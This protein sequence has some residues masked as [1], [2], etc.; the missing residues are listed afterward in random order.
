[1]VEVVAP[2][3]S[4]DAREGFLKLIKLSGECL[5]CVAVVAEGEGFA[6]SM[7]RTVVA[8]M[9]IL[10]RPAV[11]MKVFSTVSDAATWIASQRKSTD[12]V[13][14]SADEITAAAERVR[15]SMPVNPT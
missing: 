5:K 14:L 7:V 9:T 3:P 2:P 8:G 11:P 6:V 10:V 12:R 1:M 15:G 13:S 4:S